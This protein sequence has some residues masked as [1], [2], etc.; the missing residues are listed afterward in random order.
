MYSRRSMEIKALADGEW[1]NVGDMIQVVDMYDIEQQG[2][3]IDRRDGNT[4]YASELLEDKP[5]MFVVI[6]DALGSVSDRLPVTVTGMYTFE[7]ALPSDFTLNIFDGH[8]VQSQS[9]YVMSTTEELDSTLW[10]ISQK[11]PGT[12]GTTSVTCSEYSDL[13]YDYTNPVT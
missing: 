3:Y 12:D 13:M 7:C 11:N 6:T 1:V 8:G 2:G 5:D 10:V 9:R 4:F